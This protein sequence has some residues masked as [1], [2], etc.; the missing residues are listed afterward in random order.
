VSRTVPE[1]S[2]RHGLFYAVTDEGLEVPV[3]DVTHGAFRIE[4]SPAEL[5]DTSAQ[6][7]RMLK[8]SMSVPVMLQK[9]LT[10]GSILLREAYGTE[11]FLS[12]TTTY[13]QKLGPDNL[14]AGYASDLDRTIAA[15]IGP[16]CLR[17]RLQQTSRLLADLLSPALAASPGVPLE[18]ISIG[19]GPA[20][21]CWNAMIIQRREAPASLEGRSIRIRS[22]DLDREG[23]AF[24]ARCVEALRTEGAPLHGLDVAFLPVAY[25]W[26]DPS[27]LCRALAEL[28]PAVAIGST[29]GG[30]FEYGTDAQI[31]A[32]LEALRAQTPPGFV[33]TGSV[34][35]DEA[36]A[37]PSLAIMRDMRGIPPR[38]LGTD[39]FGSLATAA[40]WKIDRA[41][42]ENPCYVIV[43]LSRRS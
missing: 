9:M 20:P 28:Q 39:A 14:G 29:E 43:V 17:M 40:G 1:K 19:G 34:I 24:G 18:M 2:K 42:E 32:N 16:V 33:M 8:Q 11:R 31:V 35:R 12:G 10:K 41:I 25:D 7:L 13:L 21:E 37:D 36:T 26:A 30:L 3:I 15:S 23:P 6:S 38:L 5:A 27:A 22:L 4:P